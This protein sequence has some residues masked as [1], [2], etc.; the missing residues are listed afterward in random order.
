MVS[1]DPSYDC[2]STVI[3]QSFHN[4]VALESFRFHFRSDTSLLLGYFRFFRNTIHFWGELP[5]RKQPMARVILFWLPPIFLLE[6]FVASFL[7]KW[8]TLAKSL[9]FLNLRCSFGHRIVLWLLL[10]LFVQYQSC[11][12]RF[13]LNVT[14]FH[15][16]YIANYTKIYNLYLVDRSYKST[17]RLH[18]STARC[19]CRFEFGLK[20]NGQISIK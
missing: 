17:A 19:F 11:S 12:S 2:S 5:D 13:I 1:S 9:I 7:R 16:V 20:E 10:N 3:N 6:L 4:R 15:K 8:L 18:K 14:S